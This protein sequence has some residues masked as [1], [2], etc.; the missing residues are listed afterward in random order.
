MAVDQERRRRRRVMRA[1]HRWR[2]ARP[3][4][5]HEREAAIVL[6]ERRK[7]M[8]QTRRWLVQYLRREGWTINTDTREAA[9]AGEE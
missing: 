1:T 4:T 2:L 7:L 5:G 8:R 9:P 6:A 3:A